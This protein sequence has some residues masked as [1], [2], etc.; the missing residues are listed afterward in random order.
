MPLQRSY[1]PS[2]EAELSSSTLLSQHSEAKC[3]SGGVELS[4]FITGGADA[5]R[6]HC[7]GQDAQ[8]WVLDPGSSTAE[9]CEIAV[10]AMA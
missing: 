10:T 9:A 4:F 6:M 7:H 2:R 3:K 5:L 1:F 8:L